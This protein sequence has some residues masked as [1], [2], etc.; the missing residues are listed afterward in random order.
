MNRSFLILHGLGGS[1][2]AHWQTWLVKELVQQGEKVYYP[3]LP[4]QDQPDKGE[5]LKSLDS[6]MAGI[7][8]EE[9]L[10]VI[11]HSLACILWF[12]YA[13]AAPVRRVKRVILVCPPSIRTDLKQVA[14]FFPLP[15]ELTRIGE[16]S[17]RTLIVQSSDDIYCPLED[18]VY[19]QN[20]G[21]PHLTLPRMGHIN[22]DSG[23]GPWPWILDLAL[24][25]S[26]F[27]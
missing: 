1:G 20:L 9:E 18:I 12:H 16:A 2:P 25:G 15:E 19:Y 5:W 3:E 8:E 17:E 11:A 14:S 27:L 4:E 24:S 22:V 7:P 13:S 10:T 21:V 6:V 26:A 23:H